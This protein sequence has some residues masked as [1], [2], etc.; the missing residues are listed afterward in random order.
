MAQQDERSDI[1]INISRDRI[2]GDQVGGDKTTAGD[3][4]GAGV[5]VGRESSSGGGMAAYMSE[6]WQDLHRRLL[7]V[8]RALIELGRGRQESEE[9]LTRLERDHEL[10]R[11]QEQYDRSRLSST[12]LLFLGGS[13]FVIVMVV[14]LLLSVGGVR[15]P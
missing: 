13:L 11:W 15:V 3:I 7:E 2:G 6:L 5:A 14:V 10:R 1:Q 8:E 12:A 9:R 4:S